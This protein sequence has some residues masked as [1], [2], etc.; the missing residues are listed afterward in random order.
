[1]SQR[2]CYL[3]YADAATITSSA[4]A[5]GYPKENAQNAARWKRWRSSTTT[6]D[7][8]IDL[9]LG[10]SKTITFVGLV[11]VTQHSGGSVKAQYWD[12][13]AWQDYGTFTFSTLTGVGLVFGNQSTQK[14]RILFTNTGAVSAYV[15]IGAVRCGQYFQP[16]KQ[17]APGIGLIRTDP[18][19]F[20]TSVD[21]QEMAQ[22]RT[23]YYRFN[24]V[25]RL[26]AS[27][28]RDTFVTVYETVG[29]FSPF[30][31][32]VDHSNMDRCIY[33]RFDQALD[34]DHA[35][36]SVDKWSASVSIMEVR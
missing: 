12:G 14:I 28:D 24:G 10:S 19:E 5:T 31:Y 26:M 17:L 11:D 4:D 36:G 20:S 29:R 8:N 30:F 18:T 25:F 3:D 27:T 6:G 15:E 22:R 13:A 7:Q 2:F 33:G 23:R 16:A 34:L 9:D 21:G 32:T 35:D 1:M